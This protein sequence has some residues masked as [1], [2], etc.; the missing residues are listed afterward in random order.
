MDEVRRAARE[1]IR[2]GADFLKVMTSGGLGERHGIEDTYHYTLGELEA[3][4]EEA[5]KR[6]LRVAAHAVGAP[7]VKNAIRAG[8]RTIE[9]G[10]YADDEGLDLMAERDVV[11]VPTLAVMAAYGP[12]LKNPAAERALEATRIRVQGARTRGIRI[13]A[14]SDFGGVPLS[15]LGTNNFAEVEQLVIAGL[16]PAEV[17]VSLTKHGAAALAREN[18]IG[19]VEPGKLADLVATPADPLHDIGALRAIDVVIK[20]GSI[21]ADRRPAAWAQRP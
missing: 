1:Q 21:V 8:A 7:A 20:G 9:H 15:R 16:T 2:E 3:A 14:G 19:T 5:Q 12:G 18:D 11:Y 6:G 13:A 17:I 4:V 10:S